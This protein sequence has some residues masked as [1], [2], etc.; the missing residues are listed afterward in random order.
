M[1]QLEVIGFSLIAC[2][3]AQKAGAHRIELCDNPAEGG[4]TPSVG[5]IKAA[6]K[7]LQIPLY[8]MIRPRGGDFLYSNAEFEAMKDDIKLCK[9][10]NCDGVVFGILNSNGTVDKERCKQ[11]VNLAY[12]LE[13]TF[14]RAFDRVDNHKEALEDVIECGFTRILT[15]GLHKTA[16]EGLSII[17]DLIKQANHRIIIMPGSGIKSTNLELLMKE[18]STSEFHSSARKNIESAMQY[19]NPNMNEQLQLVA[20]NEEE[21]KKMAEILISIK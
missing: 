5:F 10:L 7:L 8:V 11:L 19:Q 4:T 15:S 18:V 21:V 13:A 17:K 9:E 6:R 3:Q 2:E 12:P 20:I 16:M 1:Y 14:H